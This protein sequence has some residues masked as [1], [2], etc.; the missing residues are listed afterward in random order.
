MTIIHVN[1]YAEKNKSQKTE[2]LKYL[3][4]TKILIFLSSKE[5]KDHINKYTVKLRYRPDAMNE[6]FTKVDPN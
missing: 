3:D 2:I 4:K 5:L 1:R 6:N